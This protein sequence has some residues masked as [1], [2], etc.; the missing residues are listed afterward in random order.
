[1]KVVEIVISAFKRIF[2]DSAGDQTTVHSV[3][4]CHKDSRV[5]QTERHNQEILLMTLYSVLIV[6]P[7]LACRK[8][9]QSHQEFVGQYQQDRQECVDLGPQWDYSPNSKTNPHA[10]AVF[11][12]HQYWNYDI[13]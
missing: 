7:V 4:D 3:G 6:R 11:S 2:G 8:S 1:M 12:W 10:P 9:R 13:L 5:Q